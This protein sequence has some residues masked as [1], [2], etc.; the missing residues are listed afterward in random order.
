MIS[1]HISLSFYEGNAN[2][3]IIFNHSKFKSGNFAINKNGDLFIEYYSKDDNNKPSSRLF[4]GLQK[5]GRELFFNQSSYTQEINI[6]LDETIDVFGYNY[7][8]IY[9]LKIKI[10]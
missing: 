9:K 5:N 7:F 10:K 8:D 6:D 1:I 3:I 4:Y 2:N